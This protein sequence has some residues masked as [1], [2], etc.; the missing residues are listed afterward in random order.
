MNL[1]PFAFAA[2]LAALAG[3]AFAGPVLRSEVVVSGA[4]V[5]VRDMFDDAGHL[6]A[7]AMFRSPAPGTAGTVTLEAVRQAAQVVGLGAYDE[8]GARQV[9][10][11]RTATVIDQAYLTRMI[12][13]DLVSRGIVTD[14][15]SVEAS[16]D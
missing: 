11:A 5:T 1:K 15:V 3:P 14:G 4:L 13:A 2:L 12:T 7:Q 6:A 8:A 10:V 9:R 16:F